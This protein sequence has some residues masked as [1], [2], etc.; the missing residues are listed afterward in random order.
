MNGLVVD[1]DADGYIRFRYKKN[2][3]GEIYDGEWLF[4][5]VSDVRAT[6]GNVVTFYDQIHS[7]TPQEETVETYTTN[8][9][10]LNEGVG[11]YTIF[12]CFCSTQ[13][14]SSIVRRVLKEYDAKFFVSESKTL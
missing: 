13:K 7:I 6:T 4:T 5:N 8:Y 9:P 3:S 14:E 11:Q 2:E 10:Y 12:N 1:A